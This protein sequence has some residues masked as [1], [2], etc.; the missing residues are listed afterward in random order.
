M[1]FAEG[2]VRGSND[3]S[4]VP[5]EC[6]FKSRATPTPFAGRAARVHGSREQ[7]PSRAQSVRQTGRFTGLAG[8]IIVRAK[9]LLQQLWW[10]RLGWDESVSQELHVQ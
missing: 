10:L 6:I 2:S 9:I 4:A 5:Y 8:L 7:S 1:G 3:S